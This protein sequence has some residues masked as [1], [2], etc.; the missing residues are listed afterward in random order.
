MG[1]G[2]FHEDLLFAS[3]ALAFRVFQLKHAKA[4]EI[5]D[6]VQ[7]L[8]NQ[9]TWAEEGP[10]WWFGGRGQERERSRTGTLAVTADAR[11]NALIVTGEGDKFDVVER[12]IEVLDAPEPAG[13][14]RVVKLYRLQHADVDVVADVLNETFAHKTRYRRWWQEPDP[15]EAR[16]RTDRR[17]KILIVY[18]TA[19]QQEEIGEFIAGIDQQ[20]ATGEQ[21]FAVLP[22]EFAQARELARTLN[23]FLRNRAQV[24]GAPPP[25]ATIVASQSANTLIVSAEADEL[26]TILQ[27]DLEAKNVSLACDV[28]AEKTIVRA[29]R[30]LL[31]QALFNLRPGRT[32]H[33]RDR[34]VCGREGL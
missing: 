30:E 26:A 12:L 13:E 10:W 11:L 16:I 2:P 6:T 34:Q 24:T 1:Q 31:R 15:T 8:S 25:T 3:Q 23:Q 29:D 5:S 9:I 22:V 20:T 17:N 28:P 33:P 32:R 27:P 14:R 19:K 21:Q 7:N 4:T 18:G